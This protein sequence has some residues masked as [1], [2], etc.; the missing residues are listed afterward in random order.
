MFFILLKAIKAGAS[1]VKEY[2]GKTPDIN[3]VHD[4]ILKAGSPEASD[5][6]LEKALSKIQRKLKE[7]GT[8]LTNEQKGLIEYVNYFSYTHSV[9]SL[10][11][12]LS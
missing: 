3:V 5:K 1:A 7:S 2:F 8:E 12:I 4:A 6:D 9:K 10:S 11:K